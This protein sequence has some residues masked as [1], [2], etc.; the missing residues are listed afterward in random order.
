MNNYRGVLF[1]EILSV[2]VIMIIII[3]VCI[4][5]F[6]V[7]KKLNLEKYLYII[8]FASL[9]GT[10]LIGGYHILNVFLDLRHNSFETYTGKCSYPARDT[11][12]LSEHD[13]TK[14]YAAISVPNTTEDITIIYAKRSKIVVGFRNGTEKILN[15]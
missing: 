3:I 11:V 7:L 1:K 14:L 4:V 2:S 15:N 6:I 5:G 12:A 13:N 8:V 10:V 9:V